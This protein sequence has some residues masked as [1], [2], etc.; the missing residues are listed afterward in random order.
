MSLDNVISVIVSRPLTAQVTVVGSI[1]KVH[2]G[3]IWIV[4]LQDAAR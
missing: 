2:D 3:K 4:T 1:G